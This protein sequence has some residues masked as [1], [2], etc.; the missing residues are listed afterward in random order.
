[1]I[2]VGLPEDKSAVTIEVDVDGQRATVTLTPDQARQLASALRLAA[3]QVRGLAYAITLPEAR[4][5][6]PRSLYGLPGT[7]GTR[8]PS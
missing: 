6:P 4:S 3:T 2:R 7:A 1:M 5:T 8:A